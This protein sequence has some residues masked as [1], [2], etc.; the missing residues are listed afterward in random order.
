M[1][2]IFEQV[3]AQV[4]QSTTRMLD[5]VG[6]VVVLELDKEQAVLDSVKEGMKK[7]KEFKLS[8]VSFQVMLE[9]LVQY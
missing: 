4:G 9:M 8:L 6:L 7:G 5:C 3:E 2:T 1:D